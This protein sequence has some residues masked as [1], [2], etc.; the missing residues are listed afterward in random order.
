MIQKYSKY[1]I[2]Q[3]FFKFPTKRFHMREISRLTKITQPSTTKH[4]KSLVEDGLILRE[5]KGL[6]PTYC[7]NRDNQEFKTYKKNDLLIELNRTEL[8]EKLYEECLPDAIVLFGSASKGEDI[9]ESDIDLFLLCSDKEINLET[10]EK[11]LHRKI[12][13]F[14]SDNFNKLSDELK[15]SI[16]NGT[17]LK[18]YLKVF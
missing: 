4:L 7:A 12:N 15:N 5:K 8:I 16:I 2:L 1:R 17:M 3:E 18:G 13:I 10:Y 14:F 9:E 11:Q 6:Y